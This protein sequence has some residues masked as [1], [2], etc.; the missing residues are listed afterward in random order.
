MT[1]GPQPDDSALARLT[2]ALRNKPIQSPDQDEID[3]PPSGSLDEL[4]PL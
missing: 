4:L 1:A 3:L 2:K